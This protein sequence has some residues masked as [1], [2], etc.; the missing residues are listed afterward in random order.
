MAPVVSSRILGSLSL[1]TTLHHHNLNDEGPASIIMDS[2][3]S[4]KPMLPSGSE[5]GEGV[6]LAVFGK[7]LCGSFS[8]ITANGPP[9]LLSLVSGAR[10]SS[11][12]DAAVP[13]L[14]GMECNANPA[15]AA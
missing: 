13:A 5:Y 7:L 2:Q 12:A 8:A 15:A 6:M 4:G 9:L 11:S 14:P 1:I 10:L 3:G